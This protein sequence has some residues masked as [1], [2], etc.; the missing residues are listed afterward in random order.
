MTEKITINSLIEAGCHFGHQTMRWNPKMKDY[1][2]GKRGDIHIIDLKKT[3]VALDETY[4]FVRELS[5]Q[6]KTILFVGTKKQAQEPIADAAN[7]C[8]MP[9][10]NAR[11]LGGFLTNFETIRKRVNHMEKLEAEEAD[12]SAQLYTKKEQIL[13]KKELTNLYR[14]ST[15]IPCW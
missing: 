6:G 2:F 8:G 4:T 11:W 14:N 5:A 9:Y 10:V 12:G 1:I 15:L 13:R 3:L 7:K